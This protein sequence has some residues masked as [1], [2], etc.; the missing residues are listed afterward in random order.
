M[1]KSGAKAILLGANNGAIRYVERL[2]PRPIKAPRCGSARTACHETKTG[3]A[4]ERLLCGDGP[5]GMEVLAGIVSARR[6]WTWV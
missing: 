4:K 5:A 1:D 3:L 2:A 6:V